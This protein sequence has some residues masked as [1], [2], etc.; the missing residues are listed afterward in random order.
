MWIEIGPAEAVHDRR[1]EPGS[2]QERAERPHRRAGG[3]ALLA[4]APT[5]ARAD[6]RAPLPPDR[7]RSTSWRRRGAAAPPRA[8]TPTRPRDRRAAL[9][10]VRHGVLHRLAA[11]GRV[12]SRTA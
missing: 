4:P 6:D 8:R 3:D 5:L 1:L 2:E 7:F 9:S 12:S 10:A 11:N